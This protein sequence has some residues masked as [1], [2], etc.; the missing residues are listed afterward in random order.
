[1]NIQVKK[2]IVLITEFLNNYEIDFT[3]TEI[4]LG[5]KIN[6]RTIDRTIVIMLRKNL[7]VF[8]IKRIGLKKIPTK[9][10]KLK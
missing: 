4:S 2:S 9:H 6:K 7:L 8:E 1:M 5:T 10:Y 3:S